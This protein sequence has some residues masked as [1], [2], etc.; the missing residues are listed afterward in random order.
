MK[1]FSVVYLAEAE[2]ELV[3]LWENASDRTRVAEAADTADET[4][5]TSPQGQSVYLGEELWRLDTKP[6][7]SYFLIR[8]DD[9]IV[10]VSNVVRV[11]D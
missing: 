5:A 4:L 11:A 2:E 7:R 8:E 10:E 9:R 6:L 3:S 1:N